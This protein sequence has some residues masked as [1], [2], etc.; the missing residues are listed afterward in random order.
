MTDTKTTTPLPC[1][2][3]FH[4]SLTHD[5]TNHLDRNGVHYKDD[6]Q[7]IPYTYSFVW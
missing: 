2:N 4:Y 1:R 6:H 3:P 7:L 5:E